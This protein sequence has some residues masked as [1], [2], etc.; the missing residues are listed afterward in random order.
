MILFNLRSGCSSAQRPLI[1][2]ALFQSQ[3]QSPNRPAEP[4]TLAPCSL[5]HL[6][7]YPLPPHVPCSGHTGSRAHWAFALV[8]SVQ[9]ALSFLHDQ[10]HFL[11]E[12][13]HGSPCYPNI[14]GSLYPTVHIPL[15]CFIF[16]ILIYY[17][18][19]QPECKLR[20]GRSLCSSLSIPSTYC[21]AWHKV[22]MYL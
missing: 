14:S 12:V 11:Q 2:P 9:L 20:K 8:F 16:F 4:C 22:A 15:Y 3:N 6:A 17:L 5:F 10:L 7:F 21:S 1:D 13:T 19:P 18:S